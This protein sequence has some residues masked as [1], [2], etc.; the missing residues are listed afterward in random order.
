MEQYYNILNHEIHLQSLEMGLL[1][2]K[3]ILE[4]MNVAKS[5]N[6]NITIQEKGDVKHEYFIFTESSL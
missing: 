1:L 4:L 6:V 2:Q 3:N 5:R